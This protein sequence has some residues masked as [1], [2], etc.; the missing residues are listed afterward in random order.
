MMGF[1]KSLVE[2]KVGKV[3]DTFSAA[4]SSPIS[5]VK[6]ITT[7]YTFK[8]LTE[9]HFEKPLSTQISKTIFATAGYAG[10]LYGGAAIAAGKGAALATTLLVPKTIVGAAVRLIGVPYAI[11]RIIKEPTVVE[12]LPEIPAAAFEAGKVTDLESGIEYV[13]AHPYMSAAAIATALGAAGYSAVMIG[14]IL[15]YVKKPKIPEIPED[16][17]APPVFI[18]PPDEQLI[19]EKPLGIEGEIPLTPETTTITTGKRA[20]KRRR[21]KKTPSVRQSV[22]VDIVNKPIGMRITNKRYIRHELLN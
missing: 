13:K 8:E 10:A 17:G 20:Y 4:F 12:K 7:K 2:S 5:T 16:V 19:T 3:M 14:R 1:F 21:A 15:K 11:S 6:A 22:R 9:E 18:P